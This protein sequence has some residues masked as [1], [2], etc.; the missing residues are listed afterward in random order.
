MKKVIGIISIVLFVFITFQSCAAGLGNIIEGGEEVSGSAGVM[1]AI[2][3]LVAGIVILTSKL[4]KGLV[5]TSIVFYT[6]GGLIGI[7]NVGSYGDLK[8]WSIL[9]F[10][11]AALLIL[12]LYRRRELYNTKAQVQNDISS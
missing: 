10:I 5:I 6:I 12:E 2:C 7:T 8:I 1:L 4:K 3:M 9:S 11:F